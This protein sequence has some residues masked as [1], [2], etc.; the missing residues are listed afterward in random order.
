MVEIFGY[1]LY[2]F[3]LLLFKRSP[4]FQTRETFRTFCNPTVET[5]GYIS[6]TFFLLLF[7]HSS[8][9]QPRET[10]QAFCNPAVEIFGYI[11]YHFILLLFK[12]SPRFQPRETLNISRFFYG[13]INL[14][15]AI[16]ITVPK[17]IFNVLLEKEPLP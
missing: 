13:K 16:K 17:T 8:R 5:V 7:K 10:F 14:M 15:L 11:L 3:I 1:I 6:I 9:F 4:R 12:H 2:H